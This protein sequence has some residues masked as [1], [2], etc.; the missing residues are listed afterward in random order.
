MNQMVPGV[1]PQIPAHDGNTVMF[2][3][4]VSVTFHLNFIYK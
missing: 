1:T 3:I 4:A 2:P